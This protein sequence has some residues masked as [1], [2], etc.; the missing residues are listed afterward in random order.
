[1]TRSNSGHPSVTAT[2]VRL[3][4]ADSTY[5]PCSYH[6]LLSHATRA[7]AVHTGKTIAIGKVTK[8]IEKT[9]DLPNVAGLTLG[10]PSG[11]STTNLAAA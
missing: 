4:R 3:G 5:T 8:L 2:R 6:P 1:M 11:S 7:P 9:D 10:A